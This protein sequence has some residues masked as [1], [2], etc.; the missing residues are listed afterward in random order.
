[1]EGASTTEDVPTTEYTPPPFLC[2]PNEL[3]L[4]IAGYLASKGAKDLNSLLQ[5]NHQLSVLLTP[6]LYPFAVT[7]GAPSMNALHWAAS[8]GNLE[9]LN[10]LLPKAPFNVN[11]P[12]SLG[13]LGWTPLHFASPRN[14]AVFKLL[15]ENG[16]NPNILDTEGRTPLHCVAFFKGEEK[17]KMLVERGVDVNAEDDLGRTALRIAVS[18]GADAIAEFLLR[19]GAGT[20]QD[21][22]DDDMQKV[23]VTKRFWG[24]FV[25]RTFGFHQYESRLDMWPFARTNSAPIGCDFLPISTKLGGIKYG[26]PNVCFFSVPPPEGSA[27]TRKI[28][29]GYRGLGTQG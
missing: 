11:A 19:S 5:A 12:A 3:L 21:P 14:D 29:I 15:L 25:K 10:L 18:V 24:R 23:G 4:Q 17:I 2:L 20:I 28:A 22:Q 26:G 9:L 6:L 8:H 16:A 27:L 13:H 1:M 7:L